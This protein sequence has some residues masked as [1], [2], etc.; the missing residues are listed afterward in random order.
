MK[1]YRELHTELGN[2][3]VALEFRGAIG[4]KA[5]VSFRCCDFDTFASAQMPT[6]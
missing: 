1:G 3:Q 2:F 6:S 5:E 4:T